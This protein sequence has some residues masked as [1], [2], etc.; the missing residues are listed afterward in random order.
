M[1]D[2]RLYTQDDAC[3]MLNTYPR[4]FRGVVEEL[5]I[6]FKIVGGRKVFTRQ[7]IERARPHLKALKPGPKSGRHL[8]T[9]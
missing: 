6:P 1:K 3:R 5:G 9:A 7:A 8:A 2:E 4:R